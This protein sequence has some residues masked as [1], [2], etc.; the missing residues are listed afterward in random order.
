MMRAGMIALLG[1]IPTALFSQE[2]EKRPSDIAVQVEWIEVRHELLTE[3][4]ADPK[5]LKGT[6]LR[7]HL[8]KLIGEGKAQ[9]WDTAMVAVQA[10]D[11]AKIQS[12]LE[13]IY[14]TESESSALP[15]SGTGLVVTPPTNKLRGLAPGIPTAFEVRE[16][17]SE[18]EVTPV[19]LAEGSRIVDLR[20]APKQTTLLALDEQIGRKLPNGSSFSLKVPQIELIQSTSGVMVADRQYEILGVARRKAAPERRMVVMVRV[21]FMD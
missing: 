15:P 6:N 1:G 20:I 13:F 16:I 5:L 8:Q 7:V 17:G 3:L 11:R 12:Q 14:P 19:P 2:V 9:V 18:I 21:D 10:G 4:M